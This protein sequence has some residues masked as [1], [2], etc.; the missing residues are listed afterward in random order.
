M[1]RRTLA[2][3]GRASASG[4]QGGSGGSSGTES[5]S[6]GAGDA[7]S[8]A[9]A[10]AHL[11]YVDGCNGEIDAISSANG[12][13][14]QAPE[15]ETSCALSNGAQCFYCEPGEDRISPDS[16]IPAYACTS[17]TWTY[18]ELYSACD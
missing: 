14:Q 12:C 2:R 9:G 5:D 4:G 6:G 13:P 3:A 15:L 18:E 10:R 7:E 1:R 16:T 17:G 11:C 8:D